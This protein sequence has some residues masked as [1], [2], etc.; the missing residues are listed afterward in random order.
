MKYRCPYCK[1][2]IQ[3]DAEELEEYIQCPHCGEHMQNPY[4]KREN[5]GS[6][7]IG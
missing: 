4:S 3:I 1:K 5:S 7:Y 6:S 2:D